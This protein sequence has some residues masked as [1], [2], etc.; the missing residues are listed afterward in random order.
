[1]PRRTIKQ[2]ETEYR[3][4]VTTLQ[5]ENTQLVERFAA[6]EMA[7]ESMDWRR[8]T[9][10]AEHE[11]TR[12]GLRQIVNLARIMAI[13]NPIIKRGI[14]VQQ[15]YVWGQGWSHKATDPDIDA[16]LTSFFDDIRNQAELSHQ[17]LQEKEKELL[18]DGNLFFCLFTNT[19][20]GRVRV[21][22]IPFAEVESII[23]NPEDR[24]DPWFYRRVWTRETIDLQTGGILTET[25][26]AY[27]PDWRHTPISR[28][29]TIGGYPVLWDCPICH[30]RA[31]GYSDH[32]F[33]I[34]EIYAS[35]DWA[36]AYKEFLE[37][38][39]S[40]V[41]AYRRFAFQLN[42]PGGKQG[43]A[44]AKA[45]L[46]TTY[47]NAGT[48]LDGNPPPVVGS[49][50]IS[51]GDATLQPVRTSG[52]TVSADDG[53]RMLLMVAAAVGLPETFFGDVSVGSLATASSLDRPTELKM[54][55]R[56]TLWSD[57]YMGLFDYVL[58]QAVRAPQGGL[59]GVGRIVTRIEEGQRLESVEWAEG[60]DPHIDIDFPPIV[61]A[62]TLQRVQAVVSA[63]TMDGKAPAGTLDL[64]TTARLMLI[65]LGEDDV[66]EMLD[67][68]FPADADG[69]RT[70]EWP[71]R[72]PSPAA[73]QRGG[74]EQATESLREVA[75]AFRTA[76]L[77]LRE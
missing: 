77:Q 46:G 29:P 70:A 43:I 19:L 76:L 50:F 8:L 65:A 7:L 52:A 2:V 24:K 5:N 68:L 32:M 10:E 14:E 58:L 55:N 30:M 56:Q 72:E 12:E 42:T 6:L 11:F 40:I 9:M 39:A 41:R 1:M 47:G 63:A 20:T 16:V 44:S 23:F 54:R 25:R 36:R 34:S 74:D 4:A 66:D 37:D 15:L 51:S 62:D 60:V 61:N 38:W 45:K 33:G 3:E 75:A 28:P 48:G 67:A 35:I 22:T 49:T 21:R 69:N 57:V 26:T 71:G 13:K 17:A 31:G 59:A 18:T 27:Y 53:R 64:I 73:Q